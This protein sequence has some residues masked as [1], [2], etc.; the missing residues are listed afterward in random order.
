MIELMNLAA[1]GTASAAERRRL[2]EYLSAHPE[3]RSYYEALSRLV[4]RLEADP[5]PDPPAGFES[6]ILDTIHQLPVPGPARKAPASS[7]WSRGFFAPRLRPWSTFGLGLATGLFILAV[8][9][10]SRP[11]FWNAARDI[12]PS[13]VSGSM[14]GRLVEPITTI[15]VETAEGTVSGSAVI[16][17]RG[18][19]IVVDV[20][21][22]STI[23]VEWMVSF[24]SDAWTLDRVERHGTATSAFAANRDSV[25]GLHTGEGGVTLVF[26][27]PSAA[28]KAVVMKVLQ[29]GQPVFESSPSSIH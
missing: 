28:A 12:D 10:Y 11:G 24:D 15:P 9:Q 29:G 18:A 25:Q 23:P 7:S 21:L 19:D 5:I 14:T 6:R 13:D 3:A 22:Q 17:G 16:Y 4:N 20:K 2:E 26:H 8:V 27:G 1:D